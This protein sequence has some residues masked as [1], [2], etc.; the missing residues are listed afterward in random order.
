MS[1]RRAKGQAEPA[2]FSS[3]ACFLHEIE[4]AAQ[5]K[6]ALKA[7]KK[8]SKQTQASNKAPKQ[9]SKQASKR[10]VRSGSAYPIRIRRVYEPAQPGEGERVLVDRLW[11]RGMTKQRA[12]LDDWCRDAAP[13]PALRKWFGHDPKRWAVFRRKYAT[14]LREHP[15]QLEAIRTKSRAGPVTLLYGARD[16][17]INHAIV[18]RDLL[19]RRRKR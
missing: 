14:E 19:L 3:P 5:A 11:P 16:P 15:A 9:A 1:P 12:G 4:A 2:Q 7:L 17:R 18:L 8:A 6:T 13:S 10:K